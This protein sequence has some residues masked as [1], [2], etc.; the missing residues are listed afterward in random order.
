MPA[1]PTLKPIPAPSAP[2]VDST[3][4][5]TREWYEYMQALDRLVRKMA[6]AVEPL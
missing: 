1:M 5:A 6:T 2:V 4:R 3:G